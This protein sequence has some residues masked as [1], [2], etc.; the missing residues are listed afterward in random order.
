MTALA[1]VA[2]VGAAFSV[3]AFSALG[4]IRSAT[5]SMGWPTSSRCLATMSGV[6]MEALFPKE[7]RT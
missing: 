7:L 3:E 1:G 2:L 6:T 4:G 5:V